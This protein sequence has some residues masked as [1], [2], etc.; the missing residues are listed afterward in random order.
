MAV[1][2]RLHKTMTLPFFD[3][4]DVAW[5]RC[6]KIY[7]DTVER[8]Q[9]GAAKLIFPNSGFNT[10]ELNATLGLVPL[11]NRWKLHIALLTR[12]YLDGSLPLC[13]S[14]YFNLRPLYTKLD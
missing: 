11:I 10:N 7:S 12:K 3:Y 1:A 5:H 13:L 9:H 8:L 2:E 4:C 14:Y 6:E